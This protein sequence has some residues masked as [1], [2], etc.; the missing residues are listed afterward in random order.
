[1]MLIS[2]NSKN[3]F[4]LN[5]YCISIKLDVP[6][7]NNLDIPPSIVLP[8]QQVGIISLPEGYKGNYGS[9]P[10]HVFLVYSPLH[11]YTTVQISHTVVCK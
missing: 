9:F 4:S 10:L 7:V 2:S 8:I 11:C 1:M 3:I 5:K 6:V